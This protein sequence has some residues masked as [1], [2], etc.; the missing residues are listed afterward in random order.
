MRVYVIN[1]KRVR[2]AFMLATAVIAS[3]AITAALLFVA[4]AYVFPSAEAS[5]SDTPT[6][7]KTVIIDAGH[8]GEDCGA[9]SQGGAYEKDINLQIAS[10]LKEKLEEK[11]YAVIMTR[12]EDK[13]LYSEEENIKGMRK[14]SDLKN[15]CRIAE[16]HDDAIFVSIHMNSFGSPGCSGLQVYYSDASEK[17]RALAESIQYTVKSTVQPENGRVVKS[18]KGLYLLDNCPITAVLVECGFLSNPEESE[19]LSEKEYQNELSFAIVCGI[20][21][22]IEKNNA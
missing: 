22:Y 9:I 18:G 10:V 3:I 15:R 7:I 6:A 11:G 2:A 20:I 17:S 19:K 12:T 4:D 1:L 16:G 5:V 14:L 21:E 13:M 8:G